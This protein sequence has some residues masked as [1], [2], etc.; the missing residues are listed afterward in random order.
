MRSA[1]EIAYEITA[2]YYDDDKVADMIRRAREE[3]RQ[4]CIQ[5]AAK[6]NF[7]IADK[8]RAIPNR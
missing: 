8:I 5:V 6:D 3:M 1:D 4:E 2:V 7:Y